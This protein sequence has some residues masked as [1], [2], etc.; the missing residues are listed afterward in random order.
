M[1]RIAI[2]TILLVAILV[3]LISQTLQV[4]YLEGKVEVLKAGK[5][6]VLSIGDNVPAA[7]S[8]KLPEGSLLELDYNGATISIVDA[9]TYNLKNFISSSRDVKSWNLANVIG[10]KLAS[11]VNGGSNR[12]QESSAGVRGP[13]KSKEEIPW[14]YGNAES[15]DLNKAKTLINDKNFS[16][17]I[18]T[19]LDYSK[20]AGAD[21]IVFVDFYLAYAY[22]MT[23]QNA[24]A[25]KYLNKLVVDKNHPIYTDFVLLKGQLLL[26]CLSY[27]KALALFDEYLGYFPQGNTAQTVFILESYCYKGQADTTKQKASLIKAKNIDPNSESGK[28][29]NDLLNSL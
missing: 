3:P 26:E 4:N 24:M 27:K 8:V 21:D 2:A 18:K 28:Q 19:L 1:K 9:G 16:E 5:W 20:E 7:A 12:G 23:G 22:S 25:L 15:D 29:A 17:A 13:D 11:A 10:L 6:S 14:Q